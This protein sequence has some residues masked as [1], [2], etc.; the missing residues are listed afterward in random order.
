MLITFL[1]H[2][3]FLVETAEAIVVADPWVSREGAFDSAWM[4]LPQ[5]HHMAD[6]VREKL[7]DGSKARYLYLSHEHKDHF[8]PAFLDTIERRDFT[9]VLARFRRP[10]MR[11]SLAGYGAKEMVVCDDGQ[12]IPLPGGGHIKV[13]VEDSGLNRDSALLV[14][15]EGRT[16]LNINDCKLH[17]RM[18]RIAREDGPVH[19]FTGQ[20]SG[21]IWHPPCYEYEK[22]QYQTVSRKKMFSKFEAVARGIDVLKPRIFLGSAGPACFLD[23]KLVHLNFEELNIFPRAGKFFAFLQKRLKNMATELA[24]PMPGDVLDAETFRWVHLAAERVTDENFESYVRAY[25]E[26]MK[27]LFDARH[28]NLSKQ[29]IEATLV[30]LA[31][32]LQRKLDNLPLHDRVALPLYASLEEQPD[33]FLR[34][35]FQ[36][37]R[38]EPVTKILDEKRYTFRAGASDVARVLD[39]LLTWED[40]LLAMR[41]KMSRNPDDYDAIL[42][43]FLAIEAPDLPAFCEAVVAAESRQERM[44]VEAGGR[45]FSVHRYCP[46]QGAD[47]SEAWVEGGRYLVCPRHRWQ[48]DLEEGGK[49][50]MNATS[51]HALPVVQGEEKREEALPA[52][53]EEAPAGGA[54]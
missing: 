2:A 11:E 27:P 32:E 34:V 45:C 20:F 15:A 42:H 13:F 41:M 12:Q 6:L 50:T 24:E 9:L 26:R 29:E 44:T 38:V 35:D 3:G 22:K 47:L 4:Q 39:G 37:R 52:A 51:L 30:N 23:P 7:Q 31:A 40:F 19:V 17:D 54:A 16:F 33:L 25:A 21:A 53:N 1:G 43:G 18:P 8:D 14:H 49:C 48:F 36:R 46:H 5:N 28:R 10:E